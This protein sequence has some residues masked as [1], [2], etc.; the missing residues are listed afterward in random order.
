MDD[1]L[2]LAQELAEV[3][4]LVADD[5]VSSTLG[6]F[7]SRIVRTVPDCDA[8]AIAI[9]ADGEAEL[10]ARQDATDPTT[11][12]AQPTFTA[13][14]IAADGPLHDALTYGEPRRIGDLAADHRWPKFAAAAIN[15]GYRSCLFL[16]LPADG[17]AAAAFSL[18]SA[19]PDAFG[20]MS[21]DVAL[22]FALNAGVAFDNVQ[23]FDDSRTLIEQL[24]TALTTRNLI[25][26]AQGLLMHRYGITS[27]VAFD[28][29]KRCSQDGNVKL[30][31]LSKEFVDAQHDNRLDAALRKHGL[32]TEGG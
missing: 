31:E 1:I 16:P 15:A 28:V 32:R 30:R 23:L 2:G 27:S 3:S 17:D 26:Q 12:P 22:L 13:Q 6:R 5:D 11:E 25:G 4:R 24:R 14:L 9:L 18:F 20:G 10:I 19:E 7:V 8:A 29:L 21:Y